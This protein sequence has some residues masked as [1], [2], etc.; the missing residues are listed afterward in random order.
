VAEPG[1]SLHHPVTG[2]RLTFVE[3]R[4]TTGGELLRFDFWMLPRGFIA[5]EHY[6]P[7]QEETFVIG[8]GTA[9]FRIAGEERQAGAGETVVVPAG[10]R[11]VWWN[12][13]EDEIHA[14]LEFRP[15]LRIEEFF[16]VFFGLGAAGKTGRRG[17]PNLLWM[18]A[19][20]NEY[21]DEVRPAAVPWPVARVALAAAAPLVRRLGYRAVPGAIPAPSAA[22]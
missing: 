6:H 15:A 4:G 2:E 17:L 10:V 3:T 5:A 8:A 11:H 22:S 1:Q 14:T 19:L 21:S 9:G 13:G 20:G 12:G 16:E 18:A 7:L